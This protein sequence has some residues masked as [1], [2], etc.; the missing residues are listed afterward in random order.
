MQ[1]QRQFESYKA[2][3]LSGWGQQFGRPTGWRGRTV[4]YLMALKNG[5]MSR[6]AVELLE[7]EP[8]ARVLEIGFGPGKAIFEAARRATRGFVAGIDRSEVMLR[9]AGRR[10]RRFIAAGRVELRRGSV[11]ALPF[12][13]GS[14]TRVFEVNSFHHWPSPAEGLAEVRRV[15]RDGGT[16]M[17]CLRM[18]H[19]TRSFLV[20][21]GYTASEVAR[22]TRLVRGAGFHNA[23]VLHGEAGRQVACVVADR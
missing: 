12:E 23:R 20:A 15:L 10:N 5:G 16:L 21:P 14:F 17:L 18:K 3:K 13:N 4:G 2:C 6:L 9:Q 22:V 11:D 8:E 7:V 19:P 1:A